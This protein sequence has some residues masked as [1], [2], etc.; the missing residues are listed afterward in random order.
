MKKPSL[1]A[2]CAVTLFLGCQLA[3]S[4]A[5]AQSVTA[6]NFPNKP[7][8]FIVPF[9]AGSASDILARIIGE[10]LTQSLGQPVI[11][12]NRPGAGGT[13]ATA[14]VAKS[15]A[16][17]YTLLVVSAGHVV[18]PS[19]Y[20]NLPYDTLQDLSGVIPFA[21]LPAV[22]VVPGSSNYRSVKDLVNQAKKAPGTLNFASGGIGSASHINAETFIYNAGIKALHIPLKGAPEMGIEIAAARVDFGF[23]PLIAAIPQIREGKLRA[24]AVSHNQR[25]SVLPEVPTIAEAGEPGGIF[26]FWIGLLAPSKTP[27]AVIQ[28]LNKEIAAI[29]KSPEV[30]VRYATLGAET[31]D[32]SPA[33]F[34][35]QMQQDYKELGEVVRAAGV[36]IDQ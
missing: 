16:D 27:P 5:W 18:N 10:R 31:F 6:A 28:K 25:S 30:K 17:G 21:S 33:Q 11:V 34:D 36:K 2:L 8:K 22:L 23:M 20:K 12:E 24:L 35:A 13:I 26:N 1:F 4:V 29:I 9:S 32:L 14:F 15:P 19:I 7:V 3:G